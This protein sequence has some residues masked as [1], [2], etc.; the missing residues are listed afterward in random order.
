[1][2]AYSIDAEQL[3]N[4]N[5]VDFQVERNSEPVELQYWRKHPDL[6]GWMEKLY[7]AKG[8][9]N[10]SFNCVNVKLELKDIEKLEEEL[11]HLPTVKGF[12][13][14]ESMPEDLINDLEF[15]IK[16]KKALNEGK[17]IY[18]TSWW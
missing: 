4:N 7:Y 16:A 10:D 8:G 3:T 5:D 14:G 18:Y 1:M 15:I 6:H 11:N 17:V 13:F 2:F 9:K 12:F